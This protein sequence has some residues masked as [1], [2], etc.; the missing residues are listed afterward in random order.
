MTLRAARKQFMAPSVD[1]F[2]YN[3]SSIL[4]CGVGEFDVQDNHSSI[5]PHLPTHGGWQ[6]MTCTQIPT[7]RKWP[8]T[9]E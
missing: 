4:T 2:T 7:A 8:M 3:D 5:N 6:M 1:A 9:M